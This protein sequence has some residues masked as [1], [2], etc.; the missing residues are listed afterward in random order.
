M[1]SRIMRGTYIIF[2]AR[3]SVLDLDNM[4]K[5]KENQR[6][7]ARTRACDH[8]VTDENERQTDIQIKYRNNFLT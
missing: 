8:S 6:E 2:N 7:L 4:Q 3:F 5:L 1:N